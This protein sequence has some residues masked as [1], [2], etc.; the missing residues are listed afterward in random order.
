VR[1]RY[2]YG[3]GRP[4]ASFEVLEVD[5]SGAAS[6]IAGNPWPKQPPFDEI[7]AYRGDT[8][9]GPL[10]ELAEAALAGG[11]TAPW[12]ADSGVESVEL[13]GASAGWDPEDPSASAAA[14]VRAAREAIARLRESPVAAAH[15]ELV[16]GGSGIVVDNRGTEPLEVAD[17]HAYVERREEVA[18]GGPSPLRLARRPPLELALPGSLAP[19]SSIELP[20]E[21]AEG[22]GRLLTA[23]VGMSWKPP[24]DPGEGGGRLEGWILAQPVS[25]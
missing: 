14:F 20:L 15:A 5:E 2:R 10:L 9:A 23:L 17:G 7:G 21:V 4:P 11:A 6:Y 12:S 8:D 22:E 19:G 1:L 25:A 13:D 18:Q 3:G 16:A 24:I